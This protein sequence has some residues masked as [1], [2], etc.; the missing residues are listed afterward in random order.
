MFSA[1][2]IVSLLLSLQVM[3]QGERQQFSQCLRAFMNEKIEQG[4]SASDFDTAIAAACQ[5]QETAYRTAYIAAAVRAGDRRPMAETDAT[6]EVT[7]LRA[8]YK[9]LFRG[10]Q[11]E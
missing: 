6:T 1:S 2:L 11:A 3:A 5:Q 4:M 8:N 9:E 10:S 7:D